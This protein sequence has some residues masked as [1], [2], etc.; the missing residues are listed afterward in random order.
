MKYFVFSDCH[1]DYIALL[2]GLNDAHYNP[3]D[4]THQIIGL[5]DYFGRAERETS[6]SLNV[7]RYLTSFIHVNPPILLK[8]NHELILENMIKRRYP[9][10]TDISNG[11]HKT[12]AS[13]SGLPLS[14]VVYSPAAF[15]TEEVKKFYDWLKGLPYYYETKLSTFTHA[16]LPDNYDVATEQEWHEWVWTNTYNEVEYFRAKSYRF[17]KTCFLGHWRAAD[18]SSQPDG[19]YYDSTTNIWF[20]DCCTVLTHRVDVIVVDDLPI[21]DETKN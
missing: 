19:E 17:P 9:I 12:I 8:G 18:I 21:S 1:G 6:D 14:E 7:W 15:N 20:L 13:I 2:T 5:G 10:Y 4:P 16:W 3:Q 11:E